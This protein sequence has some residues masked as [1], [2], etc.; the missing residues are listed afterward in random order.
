[1][2][3]KIMKKF[4]L[5]QACL[6][7]VLLILSVFSITGCGS[8]SGH[9]LGGPFEAD[10][11]P[12]QMSSTSPANGATGVATNSAIS[13]TFN[14]AMDPSTITTS[15][16]MVTGPGEVPVPGTVT[17][18]GTTAVF[19]PTSALAPDTEYAATITTGAKDLAGNSLVSDYTWTF[20]TG[21]FADTTAPTV[22]STSPANGATGVA[23]NSAISAAFSEAMDPATITS[24]TF[25]LT[26]PGSTPVAGTVTYSGTTAAFQP[27]S[28]LA[29]NTEYTATITTGVFDLAG[30]SLASNFVWTFTTGA[31][32]DTTAPTVDSTSPVDD[33]TGVVTNSAISATFSEAMDPSTITTS[34]FTLTGPGT[35]P[36]VG[37]VNYSDTTAV[38][39]PTTELAYD[40][41]YTVTVTTGVED[42]AGNSLAS[43]YVWTFKT[44]NAA[45]SGSSSAY[46]VWAD[47]HVVPLLGDGVDIPL[48]ETPNVSGIAPPDYNNHGEVTSVTLNT[49]LTGNI[50]TTGVIHVNASSDIRD[51][52]L[53]ETEAYTY[54]DS[55]VDD[56]V[57]SV[58]GAIPIISITADEI[59]T[60]AKVSRVLA[61]GAVTKEGTSNFTNLVIRIAGIAIP[62]PL[63]PPANYEVPLAGTILEGLAGVRIVLNEQFDSVT[64][65]GDGT[66]TR[67]LQVNGIHLY[68]GT[69]ITLTGIGTLTGELVVADSVA[70]LTY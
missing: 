59:E 31:S 15:T 8:N 61:G 67:K 48:A 50:L 53:T 12:P 68:T 25:T 49:L 44:G 6:A 10:T 69:G 14:E 57:V 23:T 52:A 18:S 56:L 35:T 37:A 64:D 36:V 29:P 38:F 34:T 9:W 46:G 63:N 47:L 5:L 51:I 33:A 42:L 16:L 4:K 24:L 22:D 7:F 54:A 62:V 20:T 13:I 41:E 2:K 39:Q 32:A 55:S 28:A 60:S 1:L 19:H 26:G 43:N 58:V 30:N 21:A 66:F 11:T 45:A 3:G 27:T 17:Y 65:N 70:E 40:T